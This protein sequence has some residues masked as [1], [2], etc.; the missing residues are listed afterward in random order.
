VAYVGGL[1][2]GTSDYELLDLFGI[3]GTVAS[4]SVVRYKH[5]GKSAGS[6]FVE[7]MPGEQALCAIASLD[8]IVFHGN[9]LLGPEPSLMR[10]SASNEPE[11]YTNESS[12]FRSAADLSGWITFG[13]QHTTFSG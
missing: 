2:H 6:R 3:Y 7:L 8:G 5:R 12:Q 11:E 1:L 13:D 10:N 4:V 9:S